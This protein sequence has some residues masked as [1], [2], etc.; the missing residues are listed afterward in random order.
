MNIM[1][2]FHNEQNGMVTDSK[3]G[4][5]LFTLQC[6]TN[7]IGCVTS[8]TTL[9]GSRPGQAIHLTLEPM[10]GFCYMEL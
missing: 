2:L 10:L 9:Q 6:G 1:T 3:M 8:G 4:G 7:Q 5:R